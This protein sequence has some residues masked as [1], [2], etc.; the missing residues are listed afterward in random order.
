MQNQYRCYSHSC[1]ISYEVNRKTKSA[2]VTKTSVPDFNLRTRKKVP[3]KTNADK[4]KPVG[5]RQI[6]RKKA[7]VKPLKNQRVGQGVSRD[8][9]VVSRLGVENDES[10]SKVKAPGSC[11][12]LRSTGRNLS[13]ASTQTIHIAPIQNLSLPRFTLNTFPVIDPEPNH[14]PVH[15]NQQGWLKNSP[16]KKQNNVGDFFPSK[17]SSQ[18]RESGDAI[19]GHRKLEVCCFP[20]IN[21]DPR[22]I[23]N[24]SDSEGCDGFIVVSSKESSGKGKC[25]DNED[26]LVD[27]IYQ[28][29]D[30][31]KHIRSRLVEL[32][33]TLKSRKKIPISPKDT[34]H[35]K[36]LEKALGSIIKEVDSVSRMGKNWSSVADGSPCFSPVSGH[37]GRQNYTIT[38]SKIYDNCS[39]DAADTFHVNHSQPYSKSKNTLQTPKMDHQSPRSTLIHESR[40]NKYHAG[41]H[42][43]DSPPSSVGKESSL[44]LLKKELGSFFEKMKKETDSLMEGAELHHEALLQY[45]DRNSISSWE[46]T[47]T[48]STGL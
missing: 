37:K 39:G 4:S 18:N 24:E 47:S 15:E 42:S 34:K 3:R 2:S 46:I 48:D 30:K 21:I 44:T 28:A 8:V 33:H 35:A 16:P 1:C 5:L 27:Y 22:T 14:F 7:G 17:V 41:P 25:L 32:C 9:R 20:I 6:P 26:S 12:L 31:V 23:R 43:V 36:L 10:L 29:Q 11:K 40:G 13:D 45:S 38:H 19:T